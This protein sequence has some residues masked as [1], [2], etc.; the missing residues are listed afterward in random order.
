MCPI[1]FGPELFLR[2]PR[3]GNRCSRLGRAIVGSSTI[4]HTCSMPVERRFRDALAPP[5]GPVLPQSAIALG[6]I[7]SNFS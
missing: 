4:L 3:Y 7:C 6:L 1:I 5:P 2:P